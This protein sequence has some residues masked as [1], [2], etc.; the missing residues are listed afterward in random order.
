MADANF[1]PSGL[2]VCESIEFICSLR[3]LASLWV[4]VGPD[5]SILELLR[6]PNNS[7]HMIVTASFRLAGQHS[8]FMPYFGSFG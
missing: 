1:I 6:K 3:M 7:Y 2:R 8:S 5:I 4:V